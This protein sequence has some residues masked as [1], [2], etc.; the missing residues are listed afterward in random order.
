MPYVRERMQPSAKTTVRRRV[1]DR[2]KQ[3]AA[4]T[5]PSRFDVAY[6]WL[7]SA[8]AYAGRRSYRSTAIAEAAM[9]R[10]QEIMRESAAA[11]AD[12]ARDLSRAL[13]QDRKEQQRS[14]R[15]ETE[16]RQETAPI[17]QL[18]VAHTWLLSSS[19]Q[20]NRRLNR[21]RHAG[22]HDEAARDVGRRIKI[23]DEAAARLAA[24]AEE[25]DRD[26]YG[27]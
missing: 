26:D 5:G 7:R 2:R 22:R 16:L 3:L 24:L 4:V 1:A 23:M 27:E 17:D 21:L 8:Y 12:A 14:G 25:M 6:E 10:R 9:R 20:V 15:Y 18:T 11:T 19:R 13:P